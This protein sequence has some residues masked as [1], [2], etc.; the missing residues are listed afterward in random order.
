MAVKVGFMQRSDCWGCHQSLL[1]THLR[2]LPILPTLDFVY[3]PAVVDSKHDS[4]KA[5]SNGD[6]LVGFMDKFKLATNKNNL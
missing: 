2:L 3:W 6:I 1:N 4:L 5:R